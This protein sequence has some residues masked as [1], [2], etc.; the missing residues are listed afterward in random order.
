MA[1]TLVTGEIVLPAG[2]EPFSGATATVSLESVGLMDM[3]ATIIN[4]RTLSNV[5]Y[6]G[7]AIPFTLEGTMPES[8]GHYNVR[9]HVS[10]DG[11]GDIRK[12]DYITKRAYRVLQNGTPETVRLQVDKV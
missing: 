3:P 4:K 11:S 9:A 6:S 2:T 10:V 8:G 7:A 5:S 12:G 1:T